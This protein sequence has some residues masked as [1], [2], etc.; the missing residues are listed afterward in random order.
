MS[1]RSPSRG[2]LAVRLAVPAGVLLVLL[3]GCRAPEFGDGRPASLAVVEGELAARSAYDDSGVLLTPAAAALRHRIEV[4]AART[5]LVAAQRRA[6]AAT[7]FLAFDL[8]AGHLVPVDG[9]RGATTELGAGVDVLAIAGLGPVP[10]AALVAAEEALAAATI[11]R[12]VAF[13]AALEANAAAMRLATARARERRIAELIASQRVARERAEGLEAD[14]WLGRAAAGDATRLG[15]LL[16]ERRA[17]ARRDT[18]LA[19][20]A[21]SR[22]TGL[23][24]AALE[25]LMATV[26]TANTFA[27]GDEP[28]GAD[29]PALGV[30]AAQYLVAEAR[31]RA[32]AAEYVPRISLGPAAM[33]EPD[34]LLLGGALR[35]ELRDPRAVAGEVLAAQ[36]ERD[37][38]RAR[39]IEARRAISAAARRAAVDLDYAVEAGRLAATGYAAAGAAAQY[40]AAAFE[41]EPA[42]LSEWTRMAMEHVAAEEVLAAAEFHAIEAE[43]AYLES[44]GDDRAIPEVS[45]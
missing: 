45:P 44:S 23:P 1:S 30:A 38:A 19:E 39:W 22:A 41:L 31:L 37:L 9:G 35:L 5:A 16:G 4:A 3:L 11:L 43:R 27:A 2:P 18:S 6:G 33:F 10:A 8:G 42:A 21:L 20:E 12:D 24:H 26:E 7:N 25:A 17:A 32:A 40:A 14:G 28:P 29:H 36:A 15:V 34:G 13:R